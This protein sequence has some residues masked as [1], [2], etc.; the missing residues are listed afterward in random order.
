MIPGQFDYV[1]PSSLDETLRLLADLGGDAKLISGGYSLLPLM[2]LRLAQPAV[3][4]DLKDVPGLAGLV[5]T[6]EWVRIGGRTTHRQIVEDDDLAQILPIFREAGVGIGDPQVRNWGT[7]GG[8]V[9]HADPSADW[10]A[11][12]IATGSWLICRSLAGERAIAASDFF[13]DPFVTA[14]EPTEVLTEIR[15]PMPP[16]RSGG[17]YR[18][19]ER[20]A[21]DF[22]TVGVAVQ[23]TLDGSGRIDR[24]GIG[25]T[26]VADQPFEAALAETEIRGAMPSEGMYEQA[27]AAAA[28]E[29]RPVADSHGPVDYKV[30]MVREMTKRALRRAVERAMGQ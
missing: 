5:R 18:K 11:V 15:V 3:L 20:R 25:L 22:S 2:K 29:S 28:R 16:P 4:V 14:I 24:I 6:D 23:L 19:L 10:P 13:L 7:I 21:G 26:A 1:R 12:L 17:A 27:A 30:G 8:S 9:A